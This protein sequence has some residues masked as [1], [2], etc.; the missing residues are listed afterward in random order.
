M[1]FKCPCAQCKKSGHWKDDHNANGSVKFGVVSADT[2]IIGNH[3]SG[4]SNSANKNNNSHL[5]PSSSKSN[6]PSES[7]KYKTKPNTAFGFTSALVKER[8]LVANSSR[9]HVARFDIV[10]P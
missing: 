6:K 8:T 7:N 4:S 3:N 10:G 9:V 5:T 1:K 2:P